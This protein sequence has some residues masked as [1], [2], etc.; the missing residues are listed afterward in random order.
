MFDSYGSNGY[1]VSGP[2]AKKKDVVNLTW[3]MSS[4]WKQ[5]IPK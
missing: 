4:K 5:I 2:M 3:L 1:E